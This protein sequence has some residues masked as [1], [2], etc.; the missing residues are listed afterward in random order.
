MSLPAKN[1]LRRKIEFN[2]VFKEGDAVKGTFLLVRRRK[3][4]LPE[5]RW[6][7]VVSSRIYPKATARNRIKRVLSETARD[8]TTELGGRDWLVIIRKKGSESDLKEE[9]VKLLSKK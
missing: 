7:F 9:L 5:S 4:D 3:T 1:R 2:L 6:G 8:F